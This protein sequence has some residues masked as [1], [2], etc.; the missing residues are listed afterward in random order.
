VSPMSVLTAIVL[1]ALGVY[2]LAMIGG[3]VPTDFALF[4]FICTVVSGAYFCAEAWFFA[5]RRR[6]QT[7]RTLLEFDRRS[8]AALEAR[9]D[10]VA[11]ERSGLQDQLSRRPWWVEYTAGFFPV[12]A[13]VFVLRSFLFE[14]FR[15]PSGSMIPTLQIGDL[16]LVNK[17]VYGIR[18]PVLNRTA[19]E[20]GHPQ[21]GDV[22]VFRY[23]HQPSQD[24]IKRVVGLPGDHIDY[25]D[26]TLTI[27]GTVVSMKEVGP[28]FDPGRV[29]SYLQYDETLGNVAHRVIF[30]EGDGT[31]IHPAMQHTNRDAC[32]YSAGGVAC[33][34]PP[35]SYFVMGD[36]RDN[37]ED[38]RFWGF[39]PDRNVVGRAFFIWMNFGNVGRIGRFH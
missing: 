2:V 39:V 34:V 20:L 14:P 28:Y 32:V 9:P 22:I 30:L 13:L 6:E 1:G 15:I 21:R 11:K 7:V 10:T 38:S 16:I 19:L 18:L 3:Q 23:P 35:N 5:P 12:I 33:T 31:P 29:Q 25:H 27:N 26:R 17:Y 4:L 36:N 8:K 37:S 24:Y